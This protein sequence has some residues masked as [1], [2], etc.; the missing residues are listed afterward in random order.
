MSEED[1]IRAEVGEAVTKAHRALAA[2][3]QGIVDLQPRLRESIDRAGDAQLGVAQ[4]AICEPE[5]LNWHLA[6]AGRV[7]EA[8]AARTQESN[9]LLEEVVESLNTAAHHLERVHRHAQL[10]PE[11]QRWVEPQVNAVAELLLVSQRLVSTARS[12]IEEASIG[13]GRATT[14]TGIS[15]IQ[16]AEV[17]SNSL[18]RADESIRSAD[19]VIERT[20]ATS[21][22]V[23]ATENDLQ[24][25][26]RNR[27][28]IERKNQDVSVPAGAPNWNGTPGR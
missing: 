23:L 10:D 27:Q 19:L 21:E 14:L 28:L 2:A 9:R 12:H 4:A 13:A 16:R 17:V 22:R 18:A 1:T 6:Q 11:T 15:G 24:E 8:I 20:Y 26:V 7:F 3:R 25:S 5:R